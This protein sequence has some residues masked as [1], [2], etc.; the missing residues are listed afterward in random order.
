VLSIQPK[1]NT[2]VVGSAA[3]LEVDT[4]YCKRPVWTSG[5]PASYFDCLVQ[6]RAHGMVSAAT[7]A[8]AEDGTVVARLH[9]RQ[10]GVAAG[11]ALVMYD[12]DRVI[13]AGTIISAQRKAV[14]V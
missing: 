4:I 5:A 12:G 13:G 11:Q 10:R 6:L 1:T 9:E 8:V 14:N 2:V 3:D 7:I